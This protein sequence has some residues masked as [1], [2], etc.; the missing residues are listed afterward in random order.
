MRSWICLHWNY[1][2]MKKLKCW[3]LNP[4]LSATLFIHDNTK[5]AIKFDG[6]KVKDA[7]QYIFW[8]GLLPPCCALNKA[9]HP[10]H[11]VKVSCLAHN[12]LAHNSLPWSLELVD[13]SKLSDPAKARMEMHVA[14][15]EYLYF[16]FGGLVFHYYV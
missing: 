4:S 16:V 6:Y 10:E 12:A 15:E 7:S 9:M 11:Q 14:L 8:F 1:Y 13:T 2:L 5:V 3:N